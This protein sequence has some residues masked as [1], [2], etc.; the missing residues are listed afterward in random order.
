MPEARTCHL[1]N[2]T[3]L[4]CIGVESL[5]RAKAMQRHGAD[6]VVSDMAELG[7]RR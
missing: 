7:A 6:I 4:F 3:A 5:S 1:P 2:I